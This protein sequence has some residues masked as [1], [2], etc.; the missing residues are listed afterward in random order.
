MLLLVL[1][2]TIVACSL[3]YSYAELGCTE[4]FALQSRDEPIN[5]FES[6]LQPIAYEKFLVDVLQ[7][8]PAVARRRNAGFYGALLEIDDIDTLL[9]KGKQLNNPNLS[10]AYG[11]DWKLVKRTARKGELWTGVFNKSDVTIDEA[12]EA[13]NNGGFSLIVHGVQGLWGNVYRTAWYIE[14]ALG[15][16]V[17][18]NLYM[19]PQDSYVGTIKLLLN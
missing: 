5:F 12:Q 16:R 13:F 11:K 15:W 4:H 6:L 8:Q 7:K 19:T 3:C 10:I 18:V 9:R 17:N 2:G 1:F 14:A